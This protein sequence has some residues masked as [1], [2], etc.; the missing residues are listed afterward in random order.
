MRLA[1]AA[2]L[3][4]GT[5]AEA[6]ESI[7][8]STASLKRWQAEPEFTA[9]LWEAQKEI[10]SGMTCALRSAGRDCAET[11]AAIARD[12]KAPFPSRCRAA[13][14][15]IALLVKVNHQDNVESR[16]AEIEQL[17]RQRGLTK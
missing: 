8:V 3:R 7:D 1:A 5:L 11:L 15:V 12:T 10:F 16:L 4:H 14:A 6:A 9:A 2:V 17:L 13:T